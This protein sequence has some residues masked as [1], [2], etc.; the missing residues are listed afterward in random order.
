MAELKITADMK[1]M[2]SELKKSEKAADKFQRQLLGANKRLQ[3]M[4]KDLRHLEKL[5]KTL[6]EGGEKTARLRQK[7]GG[8]NRELSTT[9]R[10]ANIAGRE[11]GQMNKKGMLAGMTFKSVFAASGLSG[12][13]GGL[14]STT[15][16]ISLM[17]SELEN[18]K[19]LQ[20]TAKD[21]QITLAAAHT[22]VTQNLF[23]S[24][25]EEIKSV[26]ESITS[27]AKETNVPERF[28]ASAMAQALSASSGDKDAS[29][30][31]VA[32]ASRFLATSPEA[33]PRFAGALLDMMKV[34][35][36][37][38]ANVNQ[39]FMQRIAANSRVVDPNMQAQNI[40]RSLIGQSSF[41][42]TAEEAS[43][44]FTALTV[45]GADSTG[46][47]TGTAAI[48][49]T[50]QLRGFF[51]EEGITKKAMKNRGRSLTAGERIGVLQQNPE[52]AKKFLKDATFEKVALGPIED[53]L[54]RKD[55]E[56]NKVFQKS[57]DKKATHEELAALAAESIK[58][59]E[60]SP[61][62][63]RFT[64]EQ[65][66]QAKLDQFD[67]A[68]PGAAQFRIEK[69]ALDETLARTATPG[70]KLFEKAAFPLDTV[71][72]QDPMKAILFSLER[73]ATR[74]MSTIHSRDS[75]PQ[76][77]S[78]SQLDFSLLLPAIQRVGDL[79]EAQTSA[80]TGA[81]PTVPPRNAGEE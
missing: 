59:F 32:G 47:R 2:E 63:A 77:I 52:L 35:G 24:S 17:R 9:A 20:E 53:L 72:A 19:T 75:S 34:T 61:H 21:K 49:L 68:R 3:E 80:M 29:A 10:R 8:T 78:K 7:L 56:T 16:A 69:N 64:Q 71:V 57:L 31:A 15:A 36:T 26:L 18:L 76:E 40:P 58:N 30:K 66:A 70:E 50:E 13:L 25:K 79:I 27:T 62:Y 44:I 22:L 51:E 42:A 39:G 55:S 45:G 67:L 38:D 5:N 14:A 73:Q 60:L 43:A 74:E 23:G 48:S 12:F 41:G 28:V 54:L 46:A 11:L 33:I 65:S 1:S 37:S 81:A 6:L 4:G